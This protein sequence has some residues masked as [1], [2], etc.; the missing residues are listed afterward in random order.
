MPKPLWEK[1]HDAKRAGKVSPKRHPKL[2]R[3][4]RKAEALLA[5]KTPE[6]R[7]LYKAMSQHSYGRTKHNL[8]GFWNGSGKTERKRPMKTAKHS[9][10]ITTFVK[11]RGETN[12]PYRKQ[13]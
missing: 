3:R 6:S 1:Y 12:K 10:G 2:E 11:L 9:R 7:K 13:T 4:F 5:D 8:Y